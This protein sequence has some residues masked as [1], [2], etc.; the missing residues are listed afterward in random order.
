MGFFGGADIIRTGAVPFAAGAGRTP[1]TEAGAAGERREPVD[2][3]TLRRGKLGSRSRA[4]RLDAAARRRGD[5]RRVERLLGRELRSL[6]LDRAL[7]V[8]LEEEREVERRR[9]VRAAVQERREV[10]LVVR[11]AAVPRRRV[12]MERAAE[13]TLMSSGIG[14]LSIASVAVSIDSRATPEAAAFR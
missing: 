9:G 7:E 13:E 8:L 2:E 5:R 3:S 1:T 12:G 6:A 10:P 11:D 14:E 4:A